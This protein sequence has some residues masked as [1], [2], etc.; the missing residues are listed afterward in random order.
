MSRLA[1]AT[2]SKSGEPVV[3]KLIAEKQRGKE[4]ARDIL[5]EEGE[6]LQQL[7][8]K[9]VVT[10]VEKGDDWIALKYISGV[11]LRQLLQRSAP[12]V[13]RALDLSIGLGETIAYLHKKGVIHRD[14]KPE[15]VLV[16]DQGKLILLDFGIALRK[17]A[18][19]QSTPKVLG[20]P[21]YMSPEQK[22][23]PQA[24]T[25]AS[26]LYSLA[27]VTYEMLIGKP[28]E[29][30][31][32]IALLPK[33]LHSLFRKALQPQPSDRP[34]DVKTFIAALKEYRDSDRLEK[35]M[36]G[37][38]WVRSKAEGIHDAQSTS[39]PTTPP[40]WNRI[41]VGV[42]FHPGAALTGLFFDF[43]D[44]PEGAK[45][46]VLGEPEE[47]VKGAAY[48]SGYIRG[49]FR[50][51]GPLTADPIQLMKMVNEIVCSNESPPKFRVSYLMLG[52]GTNSLQFVTAGP[53]QFWQIASGTQQARLHKGAD[54]LLGAKQGSN[55][56]SIKL[57]WSKGDRIVI[58]R[59]PVEEETLTAALSE[60]EQKLAQ[61]VLRHTIRQS[62]HRPDPRAAAVFCLKNSN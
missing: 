48:H 17:G 9:G 49:L 55:Y 20:T 12:S 44:L 31:V 33:G 14:I 47:G 32:K 29:G 15:N 6:I 2:D 58:S 46:L 43:L 16:N 61:T 36:R 13:Q 22:Q 18:T 8:H 37:V 24:V 5:K 59:F 39:L 42:A 10:L 38:D 30:R 53:Q 52:A 57:K 21:F 41:D 50:A 35:E 62:A 19:H 60:D 51:L 45:A 11:S 7:N 54:P 25:F 27:L 56:H 23:D 40:N 28:S 4:F 26:D 34:K 3:I 1:L